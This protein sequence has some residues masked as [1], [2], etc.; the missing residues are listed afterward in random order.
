MGE[1]RI[2]SYEVGVVVWPELFAGDGDGE[3]YG[4]GA[5]VVMVPTFRR[6]TVD[7][8]MADG[9][10]EERLV[11]WRMPYDLPLLPY[12]K[13]EKPWCA[14]EADGERD[15]MGRVWDGYQR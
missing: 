11:A 15:W 1:V 13:G 9:R 8:E 2:C 7:P 4:E 10:G 14:S 6:D 12:A 5:R 3:G